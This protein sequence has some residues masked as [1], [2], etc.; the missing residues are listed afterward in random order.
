MTFDNHDSTTL[1]FDMMSITGYLNSIGM[2][3]F[4]RKG[5]EIA[6]VTEYGL[7]ADVQSAINFLYLFSA[8]TNQGFEIFGTSDERYKIE[9][10]NQTL[11]N[12]LYE[13]VKDNVILEH[14]LIR[15][16][17][18]ATG[19][20]LTFKNGNTTTNVDADL[21]VSTIPFSVLRNVELNVALPAWKKTQLIT[22]VMV[23]IQN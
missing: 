1:K 14:Q 23:I 6:Y 2:S 15:I 8:Q 5:I 19:Y 3:G 4:I 10:G 13:Q 17:E 18:T 20:A 22:L 11:T 7:E 9:G 21:I 12:V 16:K